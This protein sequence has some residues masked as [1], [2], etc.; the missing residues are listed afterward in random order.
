MILFQEVGQILDRAMTAALA[1][2]SFGLH[3]GNRRPVKASLSGVIDDAGCRM[4]RLA[5]RLTEQALAAAASRNAE[6]RKLIVVPVESTAR[7]S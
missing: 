4:R 3:G 1:Q 5:E 2:A 7:W 6:S